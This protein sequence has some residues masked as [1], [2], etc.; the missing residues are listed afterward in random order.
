MLVSEVFLGYLLIAPQ[1]QRFFRPVSYLLIT[2][3]LF[4]LK[5]MDDKLHIRLG[6]L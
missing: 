2:S 3:R 5:Q 6:G 1:I 4:S